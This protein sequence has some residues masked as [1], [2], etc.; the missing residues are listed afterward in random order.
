MLLSVPWGLCSMIKIFPSGHVVREDTFNHIKSIYVFYGEVLMLPIA[1]TGLSNPS[2]RFLFHPWFALL[3][4][5]KGLF[6]SMVVF[7][8]ADNVSLGSITSRCS[9]ICTVQSFDMYRVWFLVFA[10]AIYGVFFKFI[11][12][13]AFIDIE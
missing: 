8:V 10:L 12:I 5:S 2:T 13:Y 7:S 11:D 3:T 4:N 6:T 1:H 9:T